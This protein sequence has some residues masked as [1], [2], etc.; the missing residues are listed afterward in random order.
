MHN[1]HT[2]HYISQETEQLT[3]TAAIHQALDAGCQ[4]VQLRVKNKTEKEVLALATA[5]KKLCGQYNAHLIIND[6]V[7]VAKEV[8][9]DGLHLGLQDTSIKAAREVLGANVIIGGTAN[10][11]ED[12]VQRAEEGTDYIGLG[13]FRFT[14]TKEKLSPILG[15]E[16]Y[17]YI[18]QQAAAAHIAIPV[19]AIGGI[20]AT[21]IPALMEAGVH[22]VAV[23]GIITNADNK[24]QAVADLYQA[25]HLKQENYVT[26]SR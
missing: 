5:V 23:C 19:I 2:L 9:A 20:T 25:L 26:N 14:A 15:L 21:D 6:H 11:W 16:G 4:W 8:A 22:G 13:P 17:R 18:M 7:Q 3:H 12:I 24:A 10:T 1:I